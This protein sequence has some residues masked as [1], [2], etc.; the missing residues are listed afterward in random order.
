MAKPGK[1][2]FRQILLSRL[3]LVSVPILLIGVY[4]TYRKARSAL[5]ETARQNVI[6]SAIRKGDSIHQSIQALNSHL[7]TASR[8]VQLQSS[9]SETLSAFLGQLQQ[10]L[11]TQVE[12]LQ[13]ANVEA[14]EVQA[15][16]CNRTPLLELPSDF[17]NAQQNNLFLDNSQVYIQPVLAPTIAPVNNPNS[18]QR[19]TLLQLLLAVPIYNETGNLE[20]ALVVKTT[21]L[22]PERLKPGSLSGYTVILNEEGTILAHP[23]PNRVGKNIS[24]EEDA[25]RLESLMKG[26][27]GGLNSFQHLYSFDRESGEELLAGYTAIASPATNETNQKW[28][29]LAVTS[30]EAALSEIKAIRRILLT[31]TF[32]LIAA[33]FLAILYIAFELSRPLEKLRDA[34]LKEDNNRLNSL[35]KNLQ[36]REFDQLAIA[37]QTMVDR[38]RNWA[39]EL[40]TAWKE[41]QTANQLKTEF[42]ATISHELRT[43]L[44]GIIGS[45]R[46]IQDGFCDNRQE[47]M[48]YLQQAD[49]S[50]IHLLGI[51]NDILDISKIEAGKS[52]I[53][54][55]ITQLK[56]LLHEVIT[57]QTSNIQ[58]KRL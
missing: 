12:C 3:L 51:I 33:N 31:M 14:E 4:V 13:L 11:P 48:E 18:R 28:V 23:F 39:V 58:Q 2:S 47:E 6:E 49:S 53:H 5:L 55:E 17:W 27:L 15:T 36:I 43:P 37:L 38:L 30:L 45:L 25:E 7:I 50:A 9:S 8:S 16:T 29:I 57:L 1:S 20:S 32:S 35:P 24:H 52:S 26:A 34:A 54:L 41:A 21:L 40:E 44:N 22:D 19:N 10:Q 46:L 42:L 56:P